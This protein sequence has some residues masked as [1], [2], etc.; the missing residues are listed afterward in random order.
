MG[1]EK[2]LLRE[3]EAYADSDFYPYHM[4]GHKRNRGL[5]CGPVGNAAGID[6][7]EIDGFDNLHEP[8]GVLRD[9]MARA[10]RLYGA[11]HTFYSVNGSTAGILTAVSAAVP[12]GGTLIM[13]RNC[14]RSVYHAVYL[15]RLTPVYLVPGTVGAVGIA[16][17]VT[18][19]QVEA[20]LREHPEAAAVLITSPT[21]DGLV[22][23]VGAIAWTAH[24]YGKP[25]LVDS[26]HGAHFGFHPKLPESAVRAGADLTVVSLHKTLPCL[27]QTALLHVR[28]NRVDRERLRLFEG[29][30]QTSSPS[31]LLMAAMDQCTALLQERGA[32]LWDGF[33]E[34]RRLFLQRAAELKR[35][36]VYTAGLPFEA[37]GEPE[38]E[39]YR[40]MDPGKLLIGT[41]GAWLGGSPL[42][43]KWLY[44]ILRD[45]WHLQMEMAEGDYVTAIMTCCDRRAGWE[46]LAE[47]LLATDAKCEGQSGAAC[48][49]PEGVSPAP[50]GKAPGI[51]DK[52]GKTG[53]ILQRTDAVLPAAV[54][55]IACALDA[56][57]EEV[58]LRDAKGRISG[59]FLNLYPPGIPLAAPGERLEEAML[60][61]L[62]ALQGRGLP[63]TGI[64]DGRVRVLA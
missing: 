38:G 18:A 19:D 40:T 26:A 17:V 35:L 15:R 16:D 57:K 13:A 22:S 56:A 24:R 34:D 21:Y 49:P 50:G 36:R 9:A 51:F 59:A 43:G 31:Y 20:A 23:D 64:R 10:A 47:A 1:E 44:D 41:A 55:S 45:E 8:E 2:G 4:P 60:E 39:A 62:E 37:G 7:T 11:D 29:I 30:Y 61:R 14:H 25:L 42:T 28:G 52:S 63:V 46:R 33:F 32:A 3:L 53:K 5:M 12:E 48:L 6:I 58:S 27:T 54:C